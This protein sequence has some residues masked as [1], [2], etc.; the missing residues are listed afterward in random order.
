MNPSFFFLYE[1]ETMWYFESKCSKFIKLLL[2]SWSCLVAQD[3]G[4]IL[5]HLRGIVQKLK[6]IMNYTYNVKKTA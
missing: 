6:S 5:K 2:G 4:S 3:L 1:H